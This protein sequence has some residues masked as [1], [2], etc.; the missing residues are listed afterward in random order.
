MEVRTYGQYCPIARASEIL[1]MRWT[2]IIVRNLLLGCET[3]GEIQDGAPGIPRTLLSQRLELLTRYGIV[4][5]TRGE[6]DRG[7]RYR[8]T[9]AGEEL[10][11][12]CDALGAW[13]ARWLEVAPP[14]LDAH[15]VVWAICRLAEHDAL[16]DRRVVIRFDL[17]DGPRRTLW[18]VLAPDAREVCIKPP[19]F[20]EDLVVTTSEEWLAKWHMGKITLGRAMHEGLIEVQGPRRLVRTFATLGLSRF[21]DVAPVHSL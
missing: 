19:G 12:V 8:L 16:P 20:D 3:F 14:H 7:W 11:S 2:P 13:G 9:A 6:H 15:V 18:L 5:R 17:L 4:E 10:A 1:A 21:A